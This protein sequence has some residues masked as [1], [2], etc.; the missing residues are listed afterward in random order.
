M[1]A[2]SDADR[3]IAD[4]LSAIVHEHGGHRDDRPGHA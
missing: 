1:R 4:R 3:L 2:T